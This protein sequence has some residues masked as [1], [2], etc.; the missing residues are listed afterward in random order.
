MADLKGYFNLGYNE[1]PH[2]GVQV[3]TTIIS[4]G[5]ERYIKDLTSK[6]IKFEVVKIPAG[7][8]HRPDLI[9]NLFYGSP[10]FMWVLLLFNQIKD[11]FQELN[12]G[13][14]IFIPELL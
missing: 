1:F 4:G 8:A 6:R 12:V 13:D 9:A 14:I 5:M 7:Y 11:P 2:K 10:S 3:P